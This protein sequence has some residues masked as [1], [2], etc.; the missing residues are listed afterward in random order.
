L[1]G[2]ERIFNCSIRNL[3]C[4]ILNLI[5]W[6]LNP[7]ACVGNSSLS[8]WLTKEVPTVLLKKEKVQC[9]LSL[10][11]MFSL[12]WHTL[13]LSLFFLK[14]GFNQLLCV[15]VL[16]SPIRWGE[17]AVWIQ[18]LLPCWTSLSHPTHL[19]SHRALSWASYTTEQVPT[20]YLFYTW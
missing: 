15:V 7:A 5:P 12:Q 3:T 17:S 14:L 16:V 10:L 11:S 4:A 6:R 18:I 2:L 9:M 20:S 13:I 8:H 19:G 1:S